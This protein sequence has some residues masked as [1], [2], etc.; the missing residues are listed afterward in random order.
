MSITGEEASQD[1]ADRGAWGNV[2]D[3]V[4]DITAALQ[5]SLHALDSEVNPEKVRRSFR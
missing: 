4:D 2:T 5:I 3:H 1:T